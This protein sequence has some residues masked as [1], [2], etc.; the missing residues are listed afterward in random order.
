MV[1]DID[2]SFAQDI[3]QHPTGKQLLTTGRESM[4]LLHVHVV[5]RLL[6]L[7]H[8]LI[9]SVVCPTAD[10]NDCNNKPTE[11]ELMDLSWDV[12]ESFDQETSELESL[13]REFREAHE[14]KVFQRR[15]LMRMVVP[16]LVLFLIVVGA[17]LS[18]FGGGRSNRPNEDSVP[19]MMGLR[20]HK[21][22]YHNVMFQSTGKIMSP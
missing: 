14:K 6:S 8:L 9:V 3:Q 5:L 20:G 22:K 1:Y 4:F 21:S 13:V 18:S 19:A 11:T 12:M 7:T 15:W 16:M 10:H 17:L 2:C